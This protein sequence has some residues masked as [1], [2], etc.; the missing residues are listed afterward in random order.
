MMG[1]LLQKSIT[2]ILDKEIVLPKNFG[3]FIALI[4]FFKRLD[5]FLTSNY[6]NLNDR[7]ILRL[8]EAMKLFYDLL[9]INVKSWFLF[10]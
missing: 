8:D 6:M 5:Y 4:F 2:E 9:N 7:I 10:N 3:L 1:K